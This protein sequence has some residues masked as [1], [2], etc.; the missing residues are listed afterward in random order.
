VRKP[1]PADNNRANCFDTENL[2]N[3]LHYYKNYSYSACQVECVTSYVIRRC[4]CRDPLQPG[5]SQAM[6]G[7]VL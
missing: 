1:P 5:K 3:P 4:G 6:Q 7:C 2:E